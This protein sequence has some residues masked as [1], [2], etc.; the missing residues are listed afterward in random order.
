MEVLEHEWGASTA[1]LGGPFDIVVGCGEGL[2][3]C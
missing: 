3:E 2:G 1:G